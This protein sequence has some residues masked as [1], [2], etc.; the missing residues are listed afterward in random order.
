MFEYFYVGLSYDIVEYA[1]FLF[2]KVDI[3]WYYKYLFY[4]SKFKIITKNIELN[5]IMFK[6]WQI[7]NIILIWSQ[8][9]NFKMFDTN[10]PK[11]NKN[12]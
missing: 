4:Y 2:P 8:S 10:I 5:Y 9:I 3:N 1:Y 12:K 11:M 6:V 7:Q